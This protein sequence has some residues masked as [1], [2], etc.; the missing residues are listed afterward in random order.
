M[1][2]VT[3]LF[4][5]T[6]QLVAG[7]VAVAQL[8][9]LTTNDLVQPSAVREVS[10]S[11]D[12]RYVAWLE[13]TDD[14]TQLARFQDRVI[15]PRTRDYH[16]RIRVRDLLA[17]ETEE[18]AIISLH[19]DMPFNLAWGGPNRLLVGAVAV[20]KDNG[21]ERPNNPREVYYVFYWRLISVDVETGDQVIM[22]GDDGAWGMRERDNYARLI[23]PLS[24][25]P[26]HVLIAASHND[27]NYDLYRVSLNTGA[28][29]RVEHGRNATV[30]WR[31][32]EFGQAVFRMDFD[33]ERDRVQIYRRDDGETRWRRTDRLTL[34]E[35][36]ERVDRARR[37]IWVADTEDPDIVLVSM[38][39]DDAERAGI[40]RYDI[41]T[42]E[43]GDLVWEHDRYDVRAVIRNAYSH[44]LIAATYVDDRVR[45][46]FF[47]RRINAHYRAVSSFFEADAVVQPIQVV[48]DAMLL[49]VTGPQEPGTYYVYRMPETS[50]TPIAVENPIL[51]QTR[52]SPVSVEN[53]AARD[54]QEIQAFLTRPQGSDMRNMP[55]IILP[56]GGPELR[57]RLGFDFIAQYFASEGWAVFQPNFRGSGG[58]GRS[59]AEAGHGEWSGLMQD[60]V[61]DGV[62]WLIEQGYADPDR[63]CIAGFSYGGYA[64]LAGAYSTPDL[65]QCAVAVAGVTDLPAFLA[66]EAKDDPEG[67]EYWRVHMGDPETDMDA[68][69]DVSPTTHAGEIRIPVLLLHGDEDRTVP[70]EQSVLMN[71]ALQAAGAHVR[72]RTLRGADHD[73]DAPI[74]LART[75]ALMEAFIGESLDQGP[76]PDDRQT[77]NDLTATRGFNLGRSIEERMDSFTSYTDDPY[78]DWL[79]GPPSQEGDETE[80]SETALP[81]PPPNTQGSS[82]R[83]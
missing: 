17:P 1:R 33:A 77:W 72:F 10:L 19:T 3:L 42:D 80:G 7:S 71:E 31:T 15:D 25:D 83:D 9:P 52:L 70:H 23:D 28:A 73:F 53:Y 20:S 18:P 60:D 21:H 35:Y 26:D 34:E 8:R 47:D 4:F 57:D 78:E 24:E 45:M 22:F 48:D 43:L 56:H 5:L 76:P 51:F 40:Y 32:N 64:A 39:P 62:H 58:M 38:R 37:S 82:D 29:R 69:V 54:G 30:S 14:Y 11:P 36:D 79:D 55:M 67:F 81:R 12:G 63:I 68:L 75:L 50:V 46:H 13:R 74:V 49:Y 41:E 27:R 61:T 2:V 66:A 16:H 6:I 44:K 65:Y 59:F